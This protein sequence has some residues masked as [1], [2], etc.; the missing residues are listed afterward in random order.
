MIT[1]VERVGRQ[2]A[3]VSSMPSLKWEFV[4]IESNRKTSLPC[5]AEK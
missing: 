4:L 3:A 2:L 5:P 1:I